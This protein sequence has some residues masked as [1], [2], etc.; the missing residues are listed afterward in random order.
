MK[1]YSRKQAA[2]SNDAYAGFLKLM[3]TPAGKEPTDSPEV[4]AY[5]DYLNEREPLSRQTRRIIGRS[6]DQAA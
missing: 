4:N 3:L 6:N 5:I 1:S 2:M